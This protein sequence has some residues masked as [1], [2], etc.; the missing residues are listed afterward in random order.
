VHV[1]TLTRIGNQRPRLSALPAEIDNTDAGD[2]V[3]EFARRFGMELDD[4]QQWVV[5]HMC[6]E[7]HDGSWSA[8][9]SVLLVP[10]Q[11]GKSAILEVIEMAALFLWDE[12][13]VIYS[14]HLGKT[15]TD[16]MRRMRSHIDAVADFRRQA[17]VLTGKGDERIERT[18]TGAILEFITRGKK[19]SRGG[20]PNR[21][22]FDEAMF[23]K[24]DQI[25]A[26]VPAL[27][28][29][30]MNQDSPPAL[31]YTSSAPIAESEV[32]HRLRAKAIKDS[33]PRMFFAEWSA[34]EG[35]PPDDREGWYVANPGLGI[36]IS[37]EWIADNELGT[38]SDDAFSVERLGI[39][40]LPA[41]EDG[42]IIPLDVWAQLLDPDSSIA[43]AEAVSL[44]VAEDRSWAAFGRA[45]L[46]ADGRFH[47]EIPE[48]RQGTAWIVDRAV[49]GY[50]RSGVPIGIEK[51]SPAAAFIEPL[52]DR[53]VEV[54]EISTME[55]AQFVGRFID[56]VTNGQLRHLG[57]GWI[58]SAIKSA[59]L[60]SSGD[61]SVWSRRRSGA[62]IS[63]L[64]AATLAVGQV[65]NA[66]TDFFVY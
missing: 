59:V 31:M 32:L 7:R 13:H 5:R 21:V 56:A 33:P 25:Q 64:V 62:D 65:S 20:S 39:P 36:R 46:R 49:Q 35:T 41:S 50:E 12:R 48:R 24:D 14:A 61:A 60:R 3:I 30:S 2:E 15:A 22:I 47:V 38:L 11:C 37:E 8:T 53:G 27:S 28:A 45:G 57:G 54:R 34:A 44:D 4:W 26:M 58:P 18:D 1:P 51:S 52:R 10:R 17:R 63:A 40:E 29:Q 66:P 6:A 9:Q 16:H 55:H 23:L 19:T 42:T 43:S